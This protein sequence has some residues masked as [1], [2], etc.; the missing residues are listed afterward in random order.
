MWSAMGNGRT[1]GNGSTA[2]LGIGCVRVSTDRQERSI[3]EQKDEIR[4]ASLRD[5]VAILDDL[6]CEDEGISGS[7][8][9]R[10]G[11]SRL[12]ALCRTRKDITDVYFWK[13][14]RLA[15]SVDPLDGM[16][17]EREIE[18][19][20]K[21]VHFVQGIQKTGHKL[22]DFLAS[23]LEYAEAGQYLVN[24]STDTIRG[25]VPLTKQGFDAGRPTPYGY[26]R[27][28][29]DADGKEVYRVRNLGNGVRQKIE[30]DGRVKTYERG[31]K[32]TKDDDTHSTLVLGDPERVAVVKRLFDAFVREGKGLRWIIDEMNAK[33]IPS[34]RGGMWS[35]GTVRTILMNPVYTGANV[36]NVRNFSK[37]H[38]IVRGSAVSIEPNGKSVRYNDRENWVVAEEGKGFPAIV[39]REVFEAAQA[40]RVRRDVPFSRGN[41]LV[42]PYYLTGFLRCA[43]GHPLHGHTKTGGK[44]K[45][46][47]KNFYY[48]CGGFS[49]M[50]NVACKR[51]LLPKEAIEKCVFDLLAKRVRR[52]AR[53][54]AI[55]EQIKMLLAEEGAP[56]GDSEASLARKLADV[57]A[58][59]RNWKTAIGKGL[60]LDMATEEL[61][62]LVKEKGRLEQ[63]LALVRN[64]KDASFDVEKISQEMLSSLDRLE[65]VF[66]EGAVAEAKAIL[67]TYIGRV[68]YDPVANKAR[69][70][71][72]KVPGVLENPPGTS[73]VSFPRHR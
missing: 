50:G 14:N 29:I 51:Y 17:I 62:A 10:P 38:A 39:S 1:N 8:L 52:L 4:A 35:L 26:D 41:A 66:R 53:V 68:E 25:L 55:R 42:V 46:R 64:R 7:I 32:P 13:R 21:R 37:Y 47:L 48:L 15:R 60:D 34:P 67:R 18:R 57:E 33:G 16:N 58:K 20:G 12:L 28:V 31:A 36:W 59:I 65:E 43:C 6:W 11:L 22:L 5:G 2:R 63:D 61:K 23:G 9:N 45:G 19:H 27:M 3:D 70:G 49:R 72:F 30:P 71:F 40:K 54:E 73:R 69:V 44:R 24:L 56:E